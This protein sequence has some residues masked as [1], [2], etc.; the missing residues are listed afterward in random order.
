MPKKV[1]DIC[2]HRPRREEAVVECDDNFEAEEKQ[3]AEQTKA[4][5]DV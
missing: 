2:I 4:L 1:P 5:S 3:T